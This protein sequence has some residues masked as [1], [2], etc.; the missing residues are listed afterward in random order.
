MRYRKRGR[1]PVERNDKDLGT[2][3]LQQKRTLYKT[4]ELLDSYYRLEK[5][6]EEQYWCGN[7]FRWLYTARYGVPNLRSSGAALFDVSTC[8]PDDPLFQQK[9][10]LKYKQATQALK[11]KQ[12]LDILFNTVIYSQCVDCSNRLLSNDNGEL[13]SS[14]LDILVDLWC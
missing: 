9:I 8:H 1:P 3:E 13:V 5:I 11:Q 12:L 7:H 4:E 10:E 6:S 2:E 14:A